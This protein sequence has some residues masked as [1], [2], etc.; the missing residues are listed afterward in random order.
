MEKHF[1]RLF[2]NEEKNKIKKKLRHK[3]HFYEIKY[4]I[5]KP[6]EQLKLNESI[7]CD[8]CHERI[9]NF[10]QHIIKKLLVYRTKQSVKHILEKKQKT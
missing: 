3:N 8:F 9:Q 10:R 4:L 6:G 1:F 7:F 5:Y 2:E